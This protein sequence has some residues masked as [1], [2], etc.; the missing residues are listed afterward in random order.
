MVQSGV[1]A[2]IK[3]LEHEVGT[4]LLLRNSK[5][6]ELTDAGAA[7]LPK[8]RA[9]LDAVQQA[10]D[11]VDSVRGGVRGT[12]RIGTISSTG[13]LDLPALLGRFHRAHPNVSL[14]LSTR[15][16]GSRDLAEAL[17]AGEL[18]LTI[19]SLPGPEPRGVTQ[20]RLLSEPMRLVVPAGHRLGTGRRVRIAD[21][22]DERFVDLPLGYGSRAVL[23]RAF[24]AAR[25]TREVATEVSDVST[26]ADYVRHGL[27]VAVLPRFAVPDDPQLRSSTIFDVDLRW[28]MSVAVSSRSTP[29]TAT[30]ILLGMLLETAAA[31]G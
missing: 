3:A 17:A 22:A 27:G 1:S 26:A 15:P 24:E 30:R 19:I 31:L 20:H 12:L 28:P 5:H 13:L 29:G 16:S 18:D 14:K 21:L 7:L 9:A 23:D 8:A 11:A 25:I 2:A 6:V 10:V 4:P